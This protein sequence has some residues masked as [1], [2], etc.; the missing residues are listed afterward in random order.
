[1]RHPPTRECREKRDRDHAK[2]ERTDTAEATKNEKDDSAIEAGETKHTTASAKERGGEEGRKEHWTQRG[3][4]DMRS[5]NVGGDRN[6]Q[7]LPQGR[8]RR[9]EERK[10]GGIESGGYLSRKLVEHWTT[11]E[12]DRE[13]DDHEHTPEPGHTRQT[14]ERS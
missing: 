9:Q 6:W 3:P 8:K 5:A 11:Q 10:E 14:Q 13:T 7:M 12:M 2:D 4:Q 1:M